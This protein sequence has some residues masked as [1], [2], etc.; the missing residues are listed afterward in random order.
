MKRKKTERN[1]LDL[2]P[3]R[4]FEH[5]LDGERATVLV[6]KYRTCWMQWLQ[7]RLARP[8]WK[9]HLDEI[10][11]AVWLE[12]D[13]QRTVA[14]IGTHLKN[15]FGEAIEPVWERLPAFLRQ[16]RRSELIDLRG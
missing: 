15:E 3:L 9:L 13:G 14:E 5:K 6:P 16:M 7:R 2:K 1:L 4:L 10:G 12:C 11:T 8:F